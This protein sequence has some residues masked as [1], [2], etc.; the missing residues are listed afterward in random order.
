MSFVTFN[1]NQLVAEPVDHYPSNYISLDLEFAYT[2]N[3]GKSFPLQVAAVYVRQGKVQPNRFNRFAYYDNMR[4]EDFV[5]GLEY[6]NTTPKTYRKYGDIKDIARHFL[7]WWAQMSARNIGQAKTRVT[8]C[9]DLLPILGYSVR[10]DLIQ[11][12]HYFPDQI[13]P[14]SLM[15]N[16]VH[17]YDVEQLVK[18]VIGKDSVPLQSLAA[19]FSIDAGRPHTAD[20]DALT[21]ATAFEIL[22]RRQQRPAHIKLSIQDASFLQQI[23]EQSSDKIM[24]LMADALLTGR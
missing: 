16:E 4:P 22:K 10:N 18:D 3:Q 17:Y 21:C 8:D 15:K 1:K 19:L 12:T 20:S 13:C 14:N 9:V 6:A 11:F 5:R 7:T 2:K 24:T 23:T